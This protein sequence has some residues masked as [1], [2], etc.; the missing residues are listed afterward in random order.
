[1]SI[2][3]DRIGEANDAGPAKLVDAFKLL[4]FVARLEIE[5]RFDHYAHSSDDSAPLWASVRE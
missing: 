2:D 3:I 5:L 1:L 4:N